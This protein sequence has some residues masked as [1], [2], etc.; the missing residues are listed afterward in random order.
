ME[1]LLFFQ[2]R[3]LKNFLFNVKKF[4]FRTFELTLMSDIIC[5]VLTLIKKGI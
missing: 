4:L 5:N 1:Q 2:D 3:Y